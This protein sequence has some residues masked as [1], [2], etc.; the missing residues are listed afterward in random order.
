MAA[1]DRSRRAEGA[2]GP[3]DGDAGGDE[4]PDRVVVG[5]V[6]RHVGERRC[7]GGQLE[8]AGEEGGHLPAVERGVGPEGA[9]GPAGGDARGDERA[10]G[11]GVRVPGGH[12]GERVLGVGEVEG[13]GEERRD[14]TAG[15]GLVGSVGAV[16]PAGGDARVGHGDD[17]IG[18]G[19]AD[20]VGE[21]RET[22]DRGDPGVVGEHRGVDGGPGAAR[23]GGADARDAHLAGTT[24]GVVDDERA[25]A[26][27]PA[28]VDGGVVHPPARTP[29]QRRVEQPRVPG[30]AVVARVHGDLAHLEEVRHSGVGGVRGAPSVHPGG[31]LVRG[32]MRLVGSGEGDRGERVAAGDGEEREVVGH[33]TGEGGGVGERAARRGDGV[34]HHLLD[35]PLGQG[36]DADVGAADD[37]DDRGSR[38]GRAVVLDDAVRR[39][40][41][42]PLGEDGAAAEALVAADGVG[43]DGH[44]VGGVGWLGG[45]AAEHRVGGGRRGDDREDGEQRGEK[46]GSEPGGHR[47]I[48]PSRGVFAADRGACE[49]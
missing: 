19:A 44:H 39:G 38:D 33:P 32:E 34:E 8:G 27:A 35:G 16:G 42:P 28:G 21:A 48:L 49:R 7:G 18:V 15:D 10:D 29:H 13:P 30:R 26:V 9:V 36:D 5:V 25:A 47:T 31:V 12:V 2:V 41:H 11:R 43:D 24:L 20:Q 23:L 45:C 4:R 46:A 1:G 17:G 40:E 37:H 3:P 22:H 6:G 14:L